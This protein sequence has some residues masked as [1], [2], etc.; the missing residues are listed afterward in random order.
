MSVTNVIIGGVARHLVETPP[1][2]THPT[3]YLGPACQRPAQANEDDEDD[4]DDDDKDDDKDDDDDDDEETCA[5]AGC[6]W[7]YS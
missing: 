7:P 4:D 5:T 6:W 3:I 2:Y 1:N